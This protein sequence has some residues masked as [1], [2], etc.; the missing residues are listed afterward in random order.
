MKRCNQTPTND[1]ERA[2]EMPIVADVFGEG[3][4]LLP[5][6]LAAWGDP[7]DLMRQSPSPA[8]QNDG[9]SDG[10]EAIHISLHG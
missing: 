4:T 5:P 9:I 1:I 2:P 7:F 10:I 8:D 6:R 3:T